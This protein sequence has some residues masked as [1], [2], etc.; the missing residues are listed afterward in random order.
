MLEEK[1]AESSTPMTTKDTSKMKPICGNG[2]NNGYGPYEEDDACTFFNHLQNSHHMP[3]GKSGW[4]ESSAMSSSSSKAEKVN[5]N[6][7]EV[8]SISSKIPPAY[9]HNTSFATFEKHT[10]GIGM[11]LISKMGYEGGGLDINDQGITYT[12]MDEERP[13]YQGLGYDQ[14]E[15]GEC[16][17]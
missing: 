15:F 11:K 1:V 16:S 13:K 6:F 4:L 8:I 3:V 7:K 12:I 17:K 10:K 9:V 5:G 14:R 2:S